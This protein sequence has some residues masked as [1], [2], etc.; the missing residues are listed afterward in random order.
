MFQTQFGDIHMAFY[1]NVGVALLRSWAVQFC[2]SHALAC[3]LSASLPAL[4]VPIS[5]HLCPHRLRPRRL[6]TSA[7][8]ASWDCVSVIST[9]HRVSACSSPLVSSLD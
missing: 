5:V 6:S 9:C 7:A 8:A 3:P 1:P 4:P 2:N